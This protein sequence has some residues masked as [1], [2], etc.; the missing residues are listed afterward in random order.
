MQSVIDRDAQ[1]L[2]Q[3]ITLTSQRQVSLQTKQVPVCRAA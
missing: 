2:L 1:P 3:V